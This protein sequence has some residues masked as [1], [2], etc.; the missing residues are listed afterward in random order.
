V[1]VAERRARRPGAISKDDQFVAAD[2]LLRHLRRGGAAGVPGALTAT[3]WQA[4]VDEA[5]RQ[6]VAALAWHR[7]SKGPLRDAIPHDTRER[8]RHLYLRSAFR[9]AVLLR[10]AA[11][12][13]ALLRERGIPVVFLKGVHLAAWI[14]PEPALRSMA[15]IDFMVPRE[16]LAEAERVF[17]GRGWGP[18]PRP[19]IIEF[20]QRFPHIAPLLRAEAI[21][22]EI[23]W[24]IERPTSPFS[25]ELDELWQ[26]TRSVELL[27]VPVN[28]LSTED[29]IVHL[30]LHASYHHRFDRAPLKSLMDVVAVASRHEGEIDW[31]RMAR[32]ANRS[33]GGRFVYCTLKL[34]REVLDAAV[35]PAAL[36]T[37]ERAPADEDMI[38]VARHYIVTPPVKLPVAYAELRD[39]HRLSDRLAWLTRAIFLPPNRMRQLYGLPPGSPLVYPYYL[40][41]PFDLLIRRGLLM[42]RVALRTPDLRP[43]LQREEGRD[44]INAWVDRADAGRSSAGSIVA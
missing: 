38:R 29:L 1:S 40:F 6:K 28:V 13:A 15:D 9:N 3:Q 19:D 14:Y 26:R 12:A 23:H 10:E 44:R 43:T 35:P 21:P 41:R 7:L 27:G 32:I 22:L 36:D 5:T 18:L 34:A 8:L 37:L 16:R 4:I 30:C 2:V 17:V 42:L 20:C 39:V 11:E 31:D 25:I 33:G 24:S